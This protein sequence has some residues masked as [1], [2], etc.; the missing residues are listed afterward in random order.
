MKYF[1]DVFGNIGMSDKVS[2][3]YA[4]I[5]ENREDAEE[6][7]KQMKKIYKKYKVTPQFDWMCLE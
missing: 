1:V 7:V 2:S 3:S 6:F 5:F 4:F